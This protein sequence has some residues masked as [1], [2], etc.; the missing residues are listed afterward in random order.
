MKCTKLF[1]SDLHLGNSFSNTDTLY[2]F[3]KNIKNCEELHLVGDIIDILELKTNPSGWK[4]K[5]TKCI[6]EILRLATTGTQ[7]YY[8]RGNH[9][10]FISNFYG[11]YNSIHIVDEQII[12]VGTK[13]YL[14]LHG[15]IF[16]GF[17]TNNHTLYWVG[18]KLYKVLIRLNMMVNKILSY[19]GVSKVSI[20]KQI[21]FSFKECL[22]A[23]NNYN[24]AVT[25]YAI[26]K[27]VDGV[28]TGHIHTPEIKFINHIHYINIGDFME[29]SSYVIE[30]SDS[31]CLQVY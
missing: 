29:N 20:S 3:L 9:D 17:L 10:N 25:K 24:V 15:D 4:K 28:I 27:G 26:S 2:K 16:D 11:Q 18:G 31:L 23:L 5:H 1:L 22:K 14:V 7:I 21:K 13:K 12:T 6:A 30:D 8:Y 19:F